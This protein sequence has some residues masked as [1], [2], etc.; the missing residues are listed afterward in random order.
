MNVL[1]TNLFEHMFFH[2]I[3]G[4]GGISRIIAAHVQCVEIICREEGRTKAVAGLG[5]SLARFFIILVQGPPRL[6]A[7]RKYGAKNR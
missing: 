1:F 5:R 6:N 4:L 7:Q 3:D 2:V